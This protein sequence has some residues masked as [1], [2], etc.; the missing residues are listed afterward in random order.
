[1]DWVNSAGGPLIF[2][3]EGFARAWMGVFGCSK[4]A[5]GQT[6]DY[7]RASRIKGY[8]E[9]V[10]C[11]GGSVLVLGD[12]PLQ[13]AFFVT[14]GGEPAIVRWVFAKARDME[15]RLK[16]PL[17]EIVE[18]AP[19][20]KFETRSDLVFL[21]DAG[22]QAENLIDKRKEPASIRNVAFTRMPPGVHNVTTEL[23]QSNGN[24]KFILHR[25]IR[26]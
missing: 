25:F 1:M 9:I 15:L 24:Y 10:E 19:A 23:I 22:G 7:D 8:I 13:S 18:L 3:E 6:T 12:E 26:Q 11:N 5:A 4:T 2:A 20:I 16:E 21:F 17:L 14:D